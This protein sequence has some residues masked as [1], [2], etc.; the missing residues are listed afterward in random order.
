MPG[1]F[2]H[3][4]VVGDDRAK[5][6]LYEQP[7]AADSFLADM[8]DD[9]TE[10]NVGLLRVNAPGRIRELADRSL[11][12]T[13]FEGVISGSSGIEPEITH[14]SLR[15]GL[16]SDPSDFPVYVEERTGVFGA[17]GTVIQSIPGH[18]MG[19]VF[20]QGRNIYIR[21]FKGQPGQ[22]YARHSYEQTLA[23]LPGKLEREVHGLGRPRR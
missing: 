19:P 14:A 22:H 11:A 5:A 23:W 6:Y 12:V 2:Q 20:Y 18:V 13:D 1:I 16:G 17:R 4:T 9:I 21:S 7:G 3:V 15:R 8:V 10:F